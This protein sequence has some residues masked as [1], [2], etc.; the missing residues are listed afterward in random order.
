MV[1]LGSDSAKAAR[2]M[3]FIRLERIGDRFL[4]LV[5]KTSIRELFFILRRL[6]AFVGPDSGPAHVAAEM[7]VPTLFLY[8]GTNVFDQWRPLSP[9]ATVLR[10]EV[11]CSPCHLTDCPVPGH[12]CMSGISAGEAA[13]WLF[14]GKTV[15]A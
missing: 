10:H 7:G 1:L 12:P 11:P 6:R 2:L 3:E 8:S 15:N 5:G 13:G 14:A 9:A 4:N